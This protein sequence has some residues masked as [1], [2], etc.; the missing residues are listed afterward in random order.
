MT[1]VDTLIELIDVPSETG[2][3]DMLA[4]HLVARLGTR[5]PIDRVGHSLVVGE[6]TGKPLLLLVGHIDTVPNQGQAA[7]QVVDG[8]VLGLGASDMKGGVAVM[9]HLMEDESLADSPYDIV[10][11][12]YEGEE[13]PSAGNGLEPVLGTHTWLH[14]AEFAL[15]LEPTDLVVEVGCNGVINAT[16]AFVGHAAH[17]ARPWHGENAVT[18]AGTFLADL[19]AREPELFKIGELEYREVVSVTTASGGVARNVLPSRFELN[20]NYRFPPMFDLEQAEGRLRESLAGADELT[21]TDRAPAGKPPE[22]NPHYDRLVEL[23]GVAPPKALDGDSLV[24]QLRAPG[25][26]TDRAVVS[27]FG[28]GNYSLRTHRWRYLLYKDG[29]EELYDMAADPNEWNN[30]GSDRADQL[31]VLRARLAEYLAT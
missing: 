5:H 21:I 3:E 9:L 22:N 4:T 30:L 16:A 28:E 29:S 15:V 11:I 12:F 25:K 8:R 13:G 20:V 18:K 26:A 7:A 24:S 2:Q 6:R 17:S 1:L 10:G 14:D 23:S 19:H 27:S 31:R